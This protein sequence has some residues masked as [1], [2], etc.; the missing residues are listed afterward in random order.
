LGNRLV[1]V[2]LK[3]IKQEEINEAV[4]RGLTVATK[5]QKRGL[6]KAAWISLRGTIKIVAPQN[7]LTQ[8]NQ[9]SKT[10]NLQ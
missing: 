4:N 2:G 5:Y 7:L 3:E 8:E 1:T 6:I 9:N 10:R